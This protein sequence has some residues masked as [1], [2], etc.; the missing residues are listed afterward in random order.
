MK[1]YPLYIAG[2][3]KYLPQRRVHNAEL[4]GQLGL[5]A[6]WIAQRTGVL[7]RR[8]VSHESSVSMATEAAKIA[9]EM[10]GLELKDI[11]CMIGAS[12]APQQALPCTAALVQRALRAPDGGSL[13]FD[14]NATC[15]SFLL[16]LQQA[17]LLLE[18][19]PY[20]H[21]LIFSSEIVSVSL[22]PREPE[23]YTLFGD[24]A[25]A[26]VVSKGTGI[27]GTARL[28]GAAFQTF[29][30]GADFTR[31]LGGGTLHHPND[32]KTTF[33]MNVFEMDGPAIFKQATRL[34]NPMLERLFSQIGWS[35]EQIDAVIPHQASKHAMEQLTRRLGFLESQVFVNLERRGNC[36]AASIP[37]A[38]VEAVETG[39]LE[40]GGRALLVG[41]A[42]GL[43]L[44]AVAITF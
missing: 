34:M 30:S 31:V 18:M 32:P 7:E 10:A 26:V 23:S 33:D 28:E 3:G 22:N 15:L 44:G 41:T 17:A 16:A 27:N 25:A 35:R 39:R 2:L 13:C 19:G 24:G 21:I 8:Y 36:V 11:D 43:T 9:I 20:Q 12:A 42:A 1:T 6:G 38:L 4:E 37:L 29:S 14:L 40:R 5:P